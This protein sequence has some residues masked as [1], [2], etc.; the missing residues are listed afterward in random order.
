MKQKVWCGRSLVS[1]W[2]KTFGQR[3]NDSGK[4]PDDSRGKSGALSIYRGAADFSWGYSR[5]SVRIPS[6][7]ITP[8]TRSEVIEAGKQLLGGRASGV[9]SLSLWTLWGFLGW[10]PPATSH[11]DLGQCLWT[12]RLGW[13]FLSLKRLTRGCIQIAGGS[14]YSDSIGRC[15]STYKRGDYVLLSNLGFRRNKAVFILVMELW[16]LWVV[17]EFPSQSTC[18]L[19]RLY[20]V[21][22]VNAVK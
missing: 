13:M 4:P 18:A 11:R 5:N 2:N 21:T 7:P 15:M 16:T 20:S 10:H 9:G 6:I 22:C 17:L 8:I 3:W 19:W 12:G 14:H 1:S